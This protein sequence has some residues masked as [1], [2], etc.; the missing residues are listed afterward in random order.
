MVCERVPPVPN[1]VIVEPLPPFP[2]DETTIWST[3]LAIPPGESV[4]LAGLI[5]HLLQDGGQMIRG[6]LEVCIETVPENPLMLVME[7]VEF[8]AVPAGIASELGLA[9]NVKSAGTGLVK[10]A[11]RM[12]SGAIPPGILGLVIVTQTLSLLVPE[13]PVG[14]RMND[15]EVERVMLYSMKNRRP[16]VGATV[17]PPC[18]TAATR[19][20]PFVGFTLLATTR[21]FCNTVPPRLSFRGRSIVGSVRTW[22]SKPFS[23]D[24]FWTFTA[25]CSMPPTVPWSIAGCE[26]QVFKVEGAMQTVPF[27]GVEVTVNNTIVECDR[28]P[29]LPV[30]LTSNVPVGPP[31]E[32]AKV[33]VDEPAAPDGK[34]ILVGLM[35]H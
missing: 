11:S 4:T 12:F 14:K 31:A 33:K 13:Q 6:G 32:E 34:L 22:I 1:T 26:G 28:L 5:V 16:V 35:L 23:A 2:K 24:E 27:R 18:C 20:R 15:P 21:T 30:T 25:I 9:D 3:A 19:T 29:L 10:L 7:I 8:A 17:T